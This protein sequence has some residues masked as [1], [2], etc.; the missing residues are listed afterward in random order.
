MKTFI[1]SWIILFSSSFHTF[2]QTDNSQT[3]IRIYDLNG[4]KINKGIVLSITDTSLKLENN[5]GIQQIEIAE[6]GTI[7][8]KHSTGNNVLWGSAIGAGALAIGG[9]AT[10][11]QD[12]GF[13]VWTPAD[14]AA[15]G[16]IVGAPLGAGIGAL[17][18]LF[19][20]SETY[21]I[22]GQV[23][24]WSTFKATISE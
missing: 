5:K 2:A 6:I 18:S 13:L 7:R 21:M 16:L 19:K 23:S 14:G 11:T 24:N 8:T 9:A 3:F 12:K 1:F 4:K 20:K 22:N 17:T 15:A 10:G